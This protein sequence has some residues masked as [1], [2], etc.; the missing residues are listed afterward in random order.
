MPPIRSTSAQKRMEQ[1][2]RILLAIDAIQKQEITS[3][4]RA[5]EVYDVPRS[6]L[7]SRLH[8]IT[9]RAETRYS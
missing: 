8:G 2:G 9:F 5:A 3:L 6:T 4:R 7:T 1:E